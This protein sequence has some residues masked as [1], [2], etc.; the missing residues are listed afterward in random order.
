MKM[1]HKWYFSVKIQV[2][3]WNIL[4]LVT[5]RY[6]YNQIFRDVLYGAQL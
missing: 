4:R 6:Y 1:F 2:K 5:V 3:V